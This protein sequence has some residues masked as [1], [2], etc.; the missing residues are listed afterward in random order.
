[1]ALALIKNTCPTIYS[2]MYLNYMYDLYD[3]GFKIYK[4]IYHTQYHFKN[5]HINFEQFMSLTYLF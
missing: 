1:M 5:M 2:V 3:V 4:H